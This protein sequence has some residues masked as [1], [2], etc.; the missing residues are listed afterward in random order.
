M[1]S[2]AMRTDAFTRIL[3]TVVCGAGVASAQTGSGDPLPLIPPEF[4]APVVF[5]VGVGNPYG[6]ASA[7]FP[8]ADG[9]PGQ[10][11]YPEI[12]VAGTGTD[13]FSPHR[14]CADEP[15]GHSI[16][17]YHNKGATVNWDG[18]DGP[19]PDDDPD[20]P[21][22]ALVETQTISIESAAPGMWAMELAFADVTGDQNGP[23][24]ILVGM[25]P[26]SSI[27]AY[28]RLLVFEN[29]GDGLF[30]TTPVV[31]TPVAAPL[32]G[33]VTA[34]FDL[35]GD[36]DIVAA[37]TQVPDEWYCSIEEQ[38]VIVVFKNV[39]NQFGFAFD[40]LPP[41][42]LGTA[43][44]AAPGDLAL[45]DFFVDGPGVPLLDLATPNLAVPS[46]TSIE[47][48]D[49]MVFLPMT[50][51]PP[52]GC[53]AG[54][55]YITATGDRFGADAHWDF[56][57]VDPNDLLLDVFSGDST[58]TFVSTCND[59]YP[60][61]PTGGNGYEFLFAHGVAS[62]KIDNGPNP[63]LVVAL[64]NPNYLG[65][66][67]ENSIIRGGVA[68][69]LGRGDG[70]FQID[71]STGYAYFFRADADT[72]PCEQRA[73]GSAKVLAVD[74]DA[75]GFDDIVLANHLVLSCD[76]NTPDT[77]TVL[78]NTLEVTGIGSP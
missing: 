17:I 40:L 6:L 23:D 1:K 51:N 20:N 55:H 12:A 2:R 35:D 29:L 73:V 19:D 42:D 36:I 74:L 57:A 68:V 67:P 52:G 37:A 7:D 53:S 77:I 4:N 8:D 47:N 50:I 41:V 65:L 46:V 43:D 16:K 44:N 9:N 69:L 24:L 58:G 3:T 28:G 13:L 49:E 34:D 66:P 60:L 54:W 59:L 22:D 38:D 30:N 45:G 25:D 56:A 78:I 70:T 32:R 62:G 31:N 15:S 10:D 48:L 11:G 21:Y 76:N 5:D 64:G 63:D 18:T 75:D 61:F 39:T 26:D 14:N 71:D 33:L 27:S 72:Y